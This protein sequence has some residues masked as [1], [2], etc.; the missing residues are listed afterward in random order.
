MPLLNEARRAQLLHTAKS[1]ATE[2]RGAPETLRN[3]THAV[4]SWQRFV[5][6]AKPSEELVWLY[7][8]NEIE[9]NRKISGIKTYLA[10]IKKYFRLKDPALDVSMFDSQ[11]IK[12]CM[13][14][15]AA[16]M[17]KAGH[18]TKRAVVVEEAHIKQICDSSKSFD[19]RLF[20]ALVVALFFNVARGAEFVHPGHS[21]SQKSNKLPLYGNVSISI[22]H[23]QIRIMSQKNDQFRPHNLDYDSSN[24]PRWARKVL[25]EYG[26][27][28]SDAS[29]GLLSLPEFFVKANGVVPTT[30][31]LADRLKRALGREY[32]PHGL[33]AGGATRMALLGYTAFEIQLAGRWTSDAFLSYVSDNE[34]L[35]RALASRGNLPNSRIRRRRH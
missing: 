20:A 6:A 27:A 25:L 21:R 15:G 19:D 31:W 35:A 5:G 22:Q 8:V 34:T 1:L 18:F 12:D 3:R 23:T 16:R 29:S 2:N 17:K 4:R 7:V 11:R 30:S 26:A 32:T 14:Q 24:C 9:K 13:W 28:R 10:G 33:R